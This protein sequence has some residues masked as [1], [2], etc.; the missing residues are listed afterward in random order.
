MSKRKLCALGYP[1]PAQE[2][3]PNDESTFRKLV[4]WVEDQKISHYAIE[5]RAALSN[6]DSADWNGAF[7]KYLSDLSCP[8]AS[9]KATNAELLDWLLGLA[10]SIAFNENAAL[11]RQKSAAELA[12][13]RGD[14][15][16]SK[17]SD[18]LLNELDYDSDEFR[19]GVSDLAKM[20]EIA[21]HPNHLITLRA[22]CTLIQDRLSNSAVKQAT[23][24]PK[25]RLGKAYPLETYSTGLESMGDAALDN[26]TR[27]LRLL[28][29]KHLR[30]LQT[31]INET[32]V[33]VQNLTANPKTDDKLG[34][35]GR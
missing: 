35:I 32:I 20:L 21:E 11:Y 4:F 1:A 25:K 14:S 2:L 19:K 5:D 16:P 10:V 33:A 12:R 22:I 34:Q 27:A 8:I 6:A 15:D 28:H 9:D 3:D 13:L 18:N 7:Q 29:V 24:D 30:D 31:D 17:T 26:A 23:E